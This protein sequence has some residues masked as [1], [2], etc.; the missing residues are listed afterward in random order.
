MDARRFERLIA[1]GP[2]G[3]GA[4]R[5]HIRGGDVP[6]RAVQAMVI[7][8]VDEARHQSP[9][10]TCVLPGTGWAARFRDGMSG[11]GHYRDARCW[12]TAFP[13]RRTGLRMVGEAAFEAGRVSSV[14]RSFWDQ[15]S[16]T[17]R[18]RHRISIDTTE[19]LRLALARLGVTV[20]LGVA[21]FD[22]DESHPHW[23]ELQS[24]VGGLDPIDIITTV[25]THQERSAARW[26]AMG[27][28]W[29]VG[30]PQPEEDFGYL[31]A[32]YD[33]SDY[34]GSCGAGAVQ[35]APFR[36]LREP[37]WGSKAVLQLNWVFDEY[38]AEIDVWHRVFRPL[39][40]A[41]RPV[42]QHLSGELLQSEVQLVIDARADGP[43]QLQT[44]PS[45]G[46]PR[47]RRRKYLPFT[48]GCFPGFV[49]AQ[50][51]IPV[52]KTRELFGSGA[53]SWAKVIVS[54]EFYGAAW[55][56]RVKG[57]SFRPMCNGDAAAARPPGASANPPL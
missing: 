15:I 44:H 45:Q 27:P 8:V 56:A 38:F 13:S 46:C 54:P 25:S 29:H 39:G 55:N 50:S 28:T 10:L 37:K 26:L 40:I 52:M 22:V 3:V 43:L 21:T 17:M 33:L 24:L 12:R 6:K 53:S 30:Y 19:A 48:R 41:A 23:P 4:T 14:T 7:V 51:P 2:D 20:Q 57:A 34:C 42:V 31:R 1:G 32:T 11:N 35:V 49:E 36:L 9:R 47:C 5:Q 16:Q 18:I